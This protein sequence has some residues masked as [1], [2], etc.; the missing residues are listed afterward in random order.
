DNRTLSIRSRDSRSSDAF[1]CL[2]AAEFAVEL[3]TENEAFPEIL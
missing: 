3:L 2:L 1:D